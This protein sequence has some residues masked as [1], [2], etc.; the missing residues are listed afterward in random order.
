MSLSTMKEYMMNI[1]ESHNDYLNYLKKV[2]AIYRDRLET[3]SREA[4]LVKFEDRLDKSD[5]TREMII[6]QAPG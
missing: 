1:D 2:K 4:R 6:K 3:K 5:L